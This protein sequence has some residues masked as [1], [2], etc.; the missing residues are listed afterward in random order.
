MVN[1]NIVLST[2][3][4]SQLDQSILN[5]IFALRHRIFSERLNWDVCS[6]HGLEYDEFDSMDP[7]YITAV[8]KS[9]E[10]AEGVWRLLPTDGAYMLKDIFPQLLAGEEAPETSNIWEISRFAVEPS[11]KESWG[12]VHSI[13]FELIRQV[14]H[15]A[16]SNGITHYVAVSSVALER[17]LKR[18]GL[19]LRRFGDGKSTMVGKVRSVAFWV[20]INDQFYDAVYSTSTRKAA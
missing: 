11:E 13:T 15:F 8:N 5:S 7:T 18:L 2:D 17:L 6:T 3:R 14:Y 10:S 4:G 1:R 12:S 9:T 16:V 20:D 19:P